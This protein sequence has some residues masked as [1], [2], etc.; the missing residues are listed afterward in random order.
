MLSKRCQGN[1]CQSPYSIFAKLRTRRPIGEPGFKVLS[2]DSEADFGV[3]QRP[4]DPG[5]KWPGVKVTGLL[6]TGKVEYPQGELVRGYEGRDEGATVVER[7]PGGLIMTVDT[8]DAGTH[9]V[10][11]AL[12]FQVHYNPSHE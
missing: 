6:A 7:F 4:E 3:S 8:P 11:M 5:R 2:P 9:V 12:S 1:L 10:T